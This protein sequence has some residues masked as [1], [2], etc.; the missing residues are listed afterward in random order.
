MNIKLVLL[1]T[2]IIAA[3]GYLN[4]VK[5][6]EETENPLE[7]NE[8]VEGRVLIRMP[9]LRIAGEA[10]ERKLVRDVYLFIEEAGEGREKLVVVWFSGEEWDTLEVD[11]LARAGTQVRIQKYTGKRDILPVSLPEVPLY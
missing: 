11:E 3:G 1:I 2:L 6:A 8:A 10:G 7:E 4:Y 5:A 9:K